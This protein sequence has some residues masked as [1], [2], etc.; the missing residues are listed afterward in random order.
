MRR[1]DEERDDCC[2]RCDI[3]R[4]SGV[5]TSLFSNILLDWIVSEFFW[6]RFY[7]MSDWRMLGRNWRIKNTV[8]D[9]TSFDV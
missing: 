8:N 3:S 5:H 4:K 7:S 1:N 2:L 6:H 9:A